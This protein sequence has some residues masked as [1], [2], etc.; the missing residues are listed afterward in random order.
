MVTLV[1]W[2]RLEGMTRVKRSPVASSAVPSTEAFETEARGTVGVFHA[3]VCRLFTES[4]HTISR[5]T[6]VKKLLGVGVSP[7]WQVFKIAATA[8]PLDT[9]GYIPRPE[10]MAKLMAAFEQAGFDK[11]NIRR[12]EEAY[13]GF[14]DFVNHHAGDRGSFDAMVAAISGGG[15]GEQ[16]E[17]RDR[18]AVFRGN[19]NIWGV[20]SHVLYR[21]VVQHLHESDPAQQVGTIVA[22][23]IGLR[24]LRRVPPLPIVKRLLITKGEGR[25]DAYEQ[26]HRPVTVLTDFCSH[27]VPQLETQEVGGPFHEMVQ[28]DGI[29]RTAGVDCFI[30]DEGPSIPFQPDYAYSAASFIHSPSEYL[31]LDMLLPVGWSDPATARARTFGNVAFT[32]K[33]ITRSHELLMPAK[34]TLQYVGTSVDALHDR[35]MPRAPELVRHVLKDRGWQQ[36]EFDI[37]RCVVRYPILHS[38]VEVSVQP[39]SP[40]E[41]EAPHN[42]KAHA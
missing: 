6:D 30:Q 10:A 32:D 18:R 35:L 20:Q 23:C 40:G 9:V 21:C 14:V 8:D 15:A 24:A 39:I 7:A 2:P 34:E 25:E 27:P 26:V 11:G 16:V 13:A 42:N 37:F 41:D 19:A 22:G 33:A 12:V 3:A 36:S 4:P 29:G 17:L 38:L 1:H 28:I 31:I 5:A